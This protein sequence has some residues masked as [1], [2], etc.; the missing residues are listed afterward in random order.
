M[1]TPP[2]ESNPFGFISYK[3][4]KEPRKVTPGERKR[5]VA[6]FFLAFI[7]LVMLP[8]G[9]L[10]ALFGLGLFSLAFSLWDNM[11][12]RDKSP[13]RETDASDSGDSDT[14]KRPTRY[15]G[16]TGGSGVSEG[17]FLYFLFHPKPALI[18]FGGLMVVGVAFAVANQIYF[19]I[20]GKPQVAQNADT[21]PQAQIPFDDRV[22]LQLRKAHGHIEK[23]E[24][25][26]ALRCFDEAIRINPNDANTFFAYFNKGRIHIDRMEYPEAI[27]D[28]TGCLRGPNSKRY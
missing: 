19:R 28:Y 16:G 15:R 7:G 6:A 14:P 22:Y 9:I 10:G 20:F 11:W 27:K 25:D 8:F 26:D 2:P 3:E 1:E 24:F 23:Q 4:A 18:V 5:K 21:K 13:K 12:A 17:Q